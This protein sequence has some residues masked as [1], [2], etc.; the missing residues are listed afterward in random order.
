M[1]EGEVVNVCTVHEFTRANHNVVVK[2]LSIPDGQICL[3]YK[4]FDPCLSKNM[5]LELASLERHLPEVLAAR[6]NKYKQVR[7]GSVCSL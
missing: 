1:G 3:H 2:A 6:L 5:E 4:L 7:S